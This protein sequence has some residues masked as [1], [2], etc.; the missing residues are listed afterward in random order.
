MT[1]RTDHMLIKE[2]RTELARPYEKLEDV[3][4]Q[5]DA[6]KARTRTARGLA[7]L[8]CFGALCVAT[9]TALLLTAI[10]FFAPLDSSTHARAR[11]FCEAL[12]E[13]DGRERNR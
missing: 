2:L 11:E 9:A 4:T 3:Q 6:S 12:A 7:A 10:S 5:L 1:F 13:Q 8:V